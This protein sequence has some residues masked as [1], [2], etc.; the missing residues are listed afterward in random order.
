ME[1]RRGL[2]YKTSTHGYGGHF[3]LQGILFCIIPYGF[4]G[5]MGFLA[6]QDHGVVGDQS[7]GPLWCTTLLCSLFIPYIFDTCLNDCNTPLATLLGTS[8]QS[9]AIQYN[10]SATKSSFTKL[11]MFRF[12]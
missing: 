7:R 12:C 6:R 5:S 2:A 11:K 1:T 8:I 9:N 10:S 4:H 3:G